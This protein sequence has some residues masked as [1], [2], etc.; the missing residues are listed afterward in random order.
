MAAT[1]Q[2]HGPTWQDSLGKLRDALVGPRP[3]RSVNSLMNSCG[4]A[5]HWALALAFLGEL[6]GL[7]LHADVF[8]FGAA[9]SA[10]K[11]V[12]QWGHAVHLLA[13]LEAQRLQSD[14]IIFSSAITAC[15]K[16]S[17]WTA[18]L[19]LFADLRSKKIQGD[20]VV[21]NAAI[22]ACEKGMQWPQALQVFTSLQQ[23]RLQPTLISF[24]SVISACEKGDQWHHALHFFSE[25]EVARMRRDV[26]AYSSII[27]ACE[28]GAQWSLAL[29][30]LSRMHWE[31]I[32]SNIITF[33]S[34][35]SALGTR[36][37]WQ[38]A[39][40]LFA[41]LSDHGLQADAVTYNAAMRA[42]E[43]GD[44]WVSALTLLAELEEHR[45]RGT[46]VTYNTAISLC[47]NTDQWP[48]AL[49][50]LGRMAFK[51][52]QADVITYSAAINACEKASDWQR[53]MSLL[54]DLHRGSIEGNVITY[55]SAMSACEKGGE[56]TLALRLLSDFAA[57]GLEANVVTYNVA[58]FAFAG[59]EQ[60]QQALHFFS[61][62]AAASVQSTVITFNAAMAVCSSQGQW[63]QTLSLLSSLSLASMQGG[64]ISTSFAAVAGCAVCLIMEVF[65][66]ASVARLAGWL[67]AG[68]LVELVV[69]ISCLHLALYQLAFHMYGTFK[70]RERTSQEVDRHRR[71]EAGD[72]DEFPWFMVILF[73]LTLGAYGFVMYGC[74][75]TSR[76]IEVLAARSE[77]VLT[78][79][80]SVSDAMGGVVVNT[81]HQG[82]EAIYGG[83]DQLLNESENALLEARILQRTVADASGTLNAT[84]QEEYSKLVML[85]Y[86]ES[87]RI[88][89]ALTGM[90][91]AAQ[92]AAAKAFL[93]S[94]DALVSTL[95][96]LTAALPKFDKQAMESLVNGTKELQGHFAEME[97]A[98]QSIQGFIEVLGGEYETF[99]LAVGSLANNSM[100]PGFRSKIPAPPNLTDMVNLSQFVES[101]HFRSLVALNVVRDWASLGAEEQKAVVEA[102]GSVVSSAQTVIQ[103][104]RRSKDGVVKDATAIVK[105]ATS[106]VKEEFALIATSAVV[107]GIDTKDNLNYAAY[108]Y[109][110]AAGGCVG[111]AVFM[112]FVA[113]AYA[114]YLEYIY[115]NRG[116]AKAYEI[117]A[118]D[119][120]GCCW[121]C[122]DTVGQF[123]HVLGFYLLV[124]LQD[125]VSILLVLVALFLCLVGDVELGLQF[126]CDFAP[127][128]SDNQAC[129][130]TMANFSA[131]VQRDLLDG[132]DCSAAGTLICEGV[133][134]N[135]SVVRATMVAAAVGAVASCCI[136]R[137]LIALSLS[138]QQSIET[139]EA[140]VAWKHGL[141]EASSEAEKV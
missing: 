106:K 34:T 89:L 54:D 62:L 84:V 101:A 30:L 131:A 42:C 100:A 37:E 46:V 40:A 72:E 74:W 4:K 117:T 81:A 85:L 56:W 24:S 105:V 21:Y 96:P 98:V 22:S 60:W 55:T 18:A 82:E 68:W 126:G 70:E 127:L 79:T 77:N 97:L 2:V 50:L 48:L 118:K 73:L 104:V 11:R 109:L 15:E 75:D 86:A 51:Q 135:P 39:L 41:E 115:E 102:A 38:R 13:D 63:E 45:L 8:T 44:Q 19:S 29:H 53:A 14:A 111:C 20:A 25:L 83:L 124:L 112:A 33:N 134:G 16:A 137:R 120:Q 136:P 91:Y 88:S 139:A 90:Q 140:I 64:K 3:M 59:G 119:R 130:A 76:R 133:S 67:A 9:I 128:L 36:G 93:D 116:I 123:V 95:Q 141:A 23:G 66:A 125:G 78:L 114:C 57:S 26:I 87:E 113:L 69:V 10:C 43:E 132:K 6:P 121:S 99:R 35:M 1:M 65:L 61:Q 28:K 103:E 49:H 94:V 122:I 52:V 129:T 27:A 47:K 138:A 17:E 80:A 32:N 71:R 58:L 110:C 107:A 92:S 7:R 31:R 12:Q 5:Q 108:L